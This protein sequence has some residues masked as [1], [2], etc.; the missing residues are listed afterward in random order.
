MRYFVAIT[1]PEPS[2]SSLARLQDR[3]QPPHWRRTIGPHI[4][5]LAPD[6]PL[7][8]PEAAGPAFSAI[9]AALPVASFSITAE[10]VLVFSRRH[11]HTL[12]LQAEPKARLMRLFDQ[13]VSVASWQQVAASTKRPY[14]PHITLANGLNTSQLAA[15]RQQL[16]QPTVSFT[17]DRL[18][19]FAKQAAWPA[20]QPL[21]TASFMPKNAHNKK[22]PNE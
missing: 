19:L 20:W 15:A 5:L 4:T 21:A 8:N 1:L 7:S 3:L 16:A 11:Y 12:V 10:D 2:Y 17:C 6:R 13:L 22:S 18:T 9:V 14:E